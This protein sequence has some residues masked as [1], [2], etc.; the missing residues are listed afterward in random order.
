MDSPFEG[1]GRAETQQLIARIATRYECPVERNHM[2]ESNYDKCFGCA[3]ICVLAIIEWQD[4]PRNDATL[5]ARQVLA[6]FYAGNP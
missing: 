5:L 3:S 1:L 4:D 2:P 6:E